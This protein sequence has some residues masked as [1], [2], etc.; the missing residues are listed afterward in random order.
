MVLVIRSPELARQILAWFNS[1][2]RADVKGS[3]QVLLK[4]DGKSLQWVALL[5]GGRSEVLDEEPEFDPWLRMRLWLLSLV[6]PES[7]L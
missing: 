4:P 7:W 1:A 5:G 2:E 3:Y 6:V